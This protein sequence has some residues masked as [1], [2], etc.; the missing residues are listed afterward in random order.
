MRKRSGGD[1][2]G[3]STADRTAPSVPKLETETVSLEVPSETVSS[4]GAI[5]GAVA[6]GASLPQS[7]FMVLAGT[8]CGISPVPP[9]QH[10]DGSASVSA[11]SMLGHAIPPSHRPQGPATGAA[12]ASPGRSSATTTR[13]RRWIPW[14]ILTLEQYLKDSD[15]VKLDCVASNL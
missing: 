3:A 8:S 10:E 13:V 12:I 1:G 15:S 14:F 5:S 9:S 2:A 11:V 4:K 7:Q 6:G